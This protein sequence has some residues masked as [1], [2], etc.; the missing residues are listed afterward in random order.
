MRIVFLALGLALAGLAD[1]QVIHACV[2]SSGTLRVVEDPT[3]CH[4]SEAPISWNQQPGEPA[5]VRVFDGL[6]TD[7]GAFA[8]AL[9]LLEFRVLR[10]DLGVTFI[11]SATTGALDRG[12][13]TYE[14]PLCQGQGHAD[15]FL[16]NTV[17]PHPLRPSV[18]LVGSTDAFLPADQ[19][20]SVARVEGVCEARSASNS[21]VVPVEEFT[22]DLGLTFPRPLP[23]WV[24]NAPAAGDETATPIPP[25]R[26]LRPSVDT[27]PGERSLGPFLGPPR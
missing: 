1:A 6:G 24:G 2:M 25:E 16:A 26:S 22:G 27:L 17:F 13:V 3:E 14:L 12:V 15:A 19:H 21:F 10:E 18:L 7:L 8:G 20:E 9:G 4:G 23:I 11:I 5:S